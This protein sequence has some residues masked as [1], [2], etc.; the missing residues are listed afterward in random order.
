MFARSNEVL[1]IGHRVARYHASID[2][3]VI[4]VKHI[5]EPLS[6]ASGFNA[7]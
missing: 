5:S 7:A 6:Y 3:V 1:V 2:R 4:T